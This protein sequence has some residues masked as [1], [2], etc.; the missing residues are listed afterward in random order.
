MNASEMDALIHH[1]KGQ[2]TASGHDVQA[3]KRDVRVLVWYLYW[4]EYQGVDRG[5]HMGIAVIAKKA[6]SSYEVGWFRGNEQRH[7]RTSEYATE[8]AMIEAIDA[9][10]A[11]RSP[12]W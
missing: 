3:H 1:F 9:E 8:E 11:T 6:D 5:H 7:F 4:G 10:I 2:K 12:I